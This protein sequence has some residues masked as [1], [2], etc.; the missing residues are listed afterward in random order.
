MC[1]GCLQVSS[2]WT[3]DGDDAG[4]WRLPAERSL[5]VTN[6]C[7][8]Q[9]AHDGFILTREESVNKE[10][11]SYWVSPLFPFPRHAEREWKE[12][13]N[14]RRNKKGIIAQRRTADLH[15]DCERR[16]QK[17]MCVF[18]MISAGTNK[19]FIR[20]RSTD[21]LLGDA[22]LI[23]FLL[24]VSSSPLPEQVGSGGGRPPIAPRHF[25]IQLLGSRGRVFQQTPASF[26]W[27]LPHP[28][29]C[30]SLAKWF[31]DWWIRKSSIS[32]AV[33][34]TWTD[35]LQFVQSHH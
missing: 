15:L 9:F 34:R 17:Q 32:W 26:I 8:I 31:T 25:L 20:S 12:N 35:Q 27:A 13:E 30:Q 6:S 2:G 23:C 24:E 19:S 33:G 5:S 16:V 1:C 22:T 28:S 18:F 14:K 10:Q 29:A 3:C 21:G 11:F 4:W 7:R